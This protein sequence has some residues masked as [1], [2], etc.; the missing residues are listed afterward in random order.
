MTEPSLKAIFGRYTGTSDPA[1]VFGLTGANVSLLF[2]SV[3]L[4]GNI[5]RAFNIR[6]FFVLFLR[7]LLGKYY[8]RR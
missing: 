7:T 6:L 8:E 3:Q 2:P 1:K 4:S 5:C